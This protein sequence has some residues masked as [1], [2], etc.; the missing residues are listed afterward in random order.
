[1]AIDLLSPL[2]VL[3]GWIWLWRRDEP[4]PTWYLA[5][6]LAIL[7]FG[8]WGD[9]LQD[10]LAGP[11]NTVLRIVAARAGMR[12]LLLVALP[13]VLLVAFGE[14][15]LVPGAPALG[16]G[17]RGVGK[18]LALGLA[19]AVVVVP[20]TV[21]AVGRPGAIT[22]PMAMGFVVVAAVS[23]EIFFRGILLLPLVPNI[24]RGGASVIAVSSFLF[25][26]SQVLWSTTG[27]LPD[28]A[29]AAAVLA[30]AVVFTLVSLRT[31]SVAGACLGRAIGR[32]APL[33]Y[34]F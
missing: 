8:I 30:I 13:L 22:D 12:L 11:A 32:L 25:T 9:M 19:G 10:L 26:R 4:T 18:S 21:L 33:F 16:L 29:L 23:E 34:A 20:L 31:R 28:P 3:L 14:G 1:M 2:P 5:P 27:I 6:T 24:G 17:R 7:A 15:S